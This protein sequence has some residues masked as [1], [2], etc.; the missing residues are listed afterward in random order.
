MD[1]KEK[2]ERAE[3]WERYVRSE[4]GAYLAAFLR[5]SSSGTVGIKYINP[6][7]SKSEAGTTYD[8][9]KAIG[10]KMVL[11]FEFEEEIDV[12]EEE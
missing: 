12:P 10:V 2:M 7:K 11:N 4:V 6:I 8:K 5:N 9:T 3:A 1:E